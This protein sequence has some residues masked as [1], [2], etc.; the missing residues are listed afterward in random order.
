MVWQSGHTRTWSLDLRILTDSF[1]WGKSGIKAFQVAVIPT[2]TAWWQP[3]TKAAPACCLSLQTL[4]FCVNG[5]FRLNTSS[6]VP[7]AFGGS[8]IFPDNVCFVVASS[9]ALWGQ[10][11]WCFLN[12][13]YSGSVYLHAVWRKF[14]NWKSLMAWRT[15]FC[16]LI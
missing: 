9:L 4:G 14:S 1:L 5:I 12:I 6:A 10:L 11:L 7:I 3:S 15:F 8:S 16:L 2:V 13:I